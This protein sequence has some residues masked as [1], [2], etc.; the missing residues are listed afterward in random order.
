MNIASLWQLLSF[1]GHYKEDVEG[2]G[3]SLIAL[4]L[5]QCFQSA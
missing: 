4:P 5:E 3:Q 1:H 2:K